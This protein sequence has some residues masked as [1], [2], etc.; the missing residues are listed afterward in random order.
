MH[1]MP[2]RAVTRRRSQMRGSASC[3][4]IVIYGKKGDGNWADLWADKNADNTPKVKREWKQGSFNCNNAEF[5]DPYP[6]TGKMCYCRESSSGTAKEKVADEGGSATCNGAVIYGKKG[7][8][9][10]S[11]LW[12]DED[13]EGNKKVARKWKC[14]S[15]NC[16]NAEFGDPYPGVGKMCYCRRGP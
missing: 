9:A 11:D 13:S 3:N 12:A 14:G 10:W 8:G 5:G 7:N 2:G 15:F 16:N 4:G 6:G 1:C